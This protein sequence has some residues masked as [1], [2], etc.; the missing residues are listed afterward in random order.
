M[1]L[2]IILSAASKIHDFFFF[3]IQDDGI[4]IAF[5]NEINSFDPSSD[6]I[7][8][9]QPLKIDFSCKIP[10][11]ISISSYY[12]LEKSNFVFT[13]SNFGSFGYSF[14]IYLDDSFT[15]PVSPTAFPVE[16]KLLQT[17]YFG[18]KAESELPNAKLFVESCVGTPTD[19][20]T[21]GIS[22]DL[23]KGGWVL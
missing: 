15:S 16:V 7:N 5:K 11:Y 9:V 19:N 14:D 3:S 1:L 10:K 12:N 8:R 23:I 21:S 18:I 20:L 2:S 22:Y 6:I 13:E 4:Y 17:I